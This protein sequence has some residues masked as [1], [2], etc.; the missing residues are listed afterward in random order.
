MR[1]KKNVST[2]ELHLKQLVSHIPYK[3][4]HVLQEAIQRDK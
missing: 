1:N 4:D 3:E 2:D